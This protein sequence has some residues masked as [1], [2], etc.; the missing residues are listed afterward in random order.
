MIKIRLI[1][2]IGLKKKVKKMLR[3]HFYLDYGS[4]T[5]MPSHFPRRVFLTTHRASTSS[6]TGWELQYLKCNQPG[7]GKSKNPE[8]NRI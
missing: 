6:A 3:I 8:K 5:T 4:S 1:T 7:S 2:G